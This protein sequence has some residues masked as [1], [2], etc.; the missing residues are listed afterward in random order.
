MQ[1][2]SQISHFQFLSVCFN[3]LTSAEAHFCG[4]KSLDLTGRIIFIS[5]ATWQN[6][7][8]CKSR[9]TRMQHLKHQQWKLTT[10]FAGLLW[11][12]TFWKGKQS[13]M[14]MKCQH[15]FAKCLTAFV[16][17]ANEAV[18]KT[19]KKTIKMMVHNTFS[20]RCIWLEKAPFWSNLHNLYVRVGSR[21]LCQNSL[22]QSH[23]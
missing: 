8:D 10:D 11:R 21:F 6:K 14:S 13:S 4:T 17:E 16:K 22:N 19:N 9:W 23:S 15:S 18:I 12:F 7:T 20:K 1:W 2:H 5:V 3:K